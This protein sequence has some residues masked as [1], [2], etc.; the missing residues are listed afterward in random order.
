MALT[1]AARGA[2]RRLDRAQRR[3]RPA[4]F[5]Y[6]VVQKFLDDRAGRQA[7]L[8]AYFSFFSVFPLLLALTTV[9]GFVLSGHPELRDAVYSSAVS[10]FPIIGEHSAIDPL[11]GNWFALT[12]G[13]VLAI[14][15]GIQV[16]Q[17]AQTAFNIVYAVPRIGGPGFVP[18]ILRSLELVAVGGGALM[19]TTFLQ[20]AVSGRETYGVHIGRAGAVLAAV[21]GIALNY[22]VFTYLFR[23]L[24]VHPVGF[25][26]AAPGA[27]LA[28]AAWF[29][30]QRAGTGLVNDKVQGAVGTYGTFAL[31]IG[32]V[33]WFYLLALIT[34]VCAE[35][36]VV[37][38]QRLW[39]RGVS[40]LNRRASTRADVRAYRLYPLREKQAHNVGVAAFPRRL[41]GWAGDPVDDAAAQGGA[42]ED[43]GGAP[44]RPLPELP[45]RAPADPS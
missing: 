14:W 11:T 45:A 1:V 16:A 20:G 4:G 40:A 23:R 2:A 33:S 39:P 36:N 22:L 18:R 10:D 7:A 9:L 8:I 31:V 25:R 19:M 27:L 30:M 38:S 44:T 3:Y 12:V 5:V 41:R 24:T 13:L 35:I 28:A 42:I 43:D 17:N 6:A 26:E 29:A 32:L 34:M 15:S 37:R 21:V